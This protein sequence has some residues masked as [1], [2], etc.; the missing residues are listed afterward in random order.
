MRRVHDSE[1]SRKG[2]QAE[3]GLSAEEDRELEK[4]L[5]KKGEKLKI[6]E[7]LEPERMRGYLEKNQREYR[8][9]NRRKIPGRRSLYPVLAAAACFCLILGLCSGMLRPK[10]QPPER[11]EAAADASLSARQGGDEPETADSLSAKEEEQEFPALTGRTYEEIYAC[12]SENWRKQEDLTKGVLRDDVLFVAETEDLA[13]AERKLSASKESFGR[14]NTQ[15]EQIDEADRIKNDGRYLY[16]IA[17]K[18]QKEE[19]GQITAQTGIQILDT[20]DGLKETAFVS[21]FESVEEFYVWEDLLVT[22]ENK[23]Y[24][25]DYG[26][27]APVSSSE[28]VQEKKLACGNIYGE[29]GYHEIGIYRIADR[30]RPRKLKIFTLQGMYKSSRISDGYFYGI[31]RFTA[32]PGEGA[33]DYDSYIPSVDGARMEPDK[34]YCPDNA[35]GTEYLVLVSIDLS[36]PTSFADSRAVLAG[37]GTYYVSRGNIYVAWYQSVYD[38]EPAAEGTVQDATRLLRFSYRKGRFYAQ[39]EGSVP[40]NVKNSFSLDEYGGKLRIAVTVQEYEAKKIRDDRTGEYLGYDY[41]EARETNALYILSSSLNIVGRLEGLAEGETIRSARFLGETGYFVTFRQTDPLFAVDLSDP[42]HPQVLGELKVS[43]FSEYLHGYG[44]HLLLGIGME[45]DEESGREQGMKLSMF[46]LSDP[47][48]PEEV[49]RLHLEEYDYS[50]ALWDHRA[51]LIDP[52]EN[53][54]G[55][56]AEGWQNGSYRE[57]YLL[58]SYKDGAFVQ[59]LKIRT[60]S[61]EENPCTARGTFI[62]NTFYLLLANGSARAYDRQTGKLLE[63]I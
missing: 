49:S 15:V 4:L 29:R 46:D 8:G 36:S 33:Q 55:F 18:E 30:S 1:K 61:E 10:E 57:D 52:E 31:S 63:E 50:E 35:D 2:C 27:V 28:A 5:R 56:E 11:N 62:G 48:E 59:E 22:I 26:I 23:Y 17:V 40:G 3:H 45:A 60:R 24:D 13:S 20:K 42:G 19:D 32:G 16:Q 58:F 21:G 34:I 47:T 25:S 9:G 54:F 39:A 7:S 41:G 14:T 51:V 37:S 44:E 6:P 12:L 53:L 43:G 38:T